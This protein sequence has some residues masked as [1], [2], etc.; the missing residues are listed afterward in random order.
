MILKLGG[1]VLHSQVGRL[2]NVAVSVHH[3]CFV[4]YVPLANA[5][6]PGSLG[7]I[8]DGAGPEITCASFVRNLDKL[9][10]PELGFDKVGNFG[11]TAS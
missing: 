5:N 1:Q 8:V 4:H 10:C 2:K 11:A 9:A 3:E 7:L 6:R